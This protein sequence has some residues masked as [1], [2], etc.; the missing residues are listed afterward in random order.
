MFFRLVFAIGAVSQALFASDFAPPTLFPNQNTG[1]TRDLTRQA[2]DR[3][4]SAA[5]LGKQQPAGKGPLPSLPV[6]PFLNRR[7]EVA[8]NSDCS[9]TL[10]QMKVDGTKRFTIKSLKTPKPD[11]DSIIKAPPLPACK[12]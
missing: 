12:Q 11:F 7:V 4:I 2:L 6:N 3:Q 10:T 8:S 5:I 9:V 1:S